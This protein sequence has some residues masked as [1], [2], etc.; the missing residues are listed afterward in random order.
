MSL[1]VPFE[2]KQFLMKYDTYLIIGHKEPDGD[3]VGSQLALQSF[4]HR[5]GKLAYAISA[6]PFTRTEIMPFEHRFHENIP[7]DHNNMAVV[8][9]DCSSISRIGQISDSI[10]LLP[11]AFIDHHAY[12]EC[13][14]DVVF[15]DPAA[16]SVTIMILDIILSM[17]DTPT[18]EEAELMFFG[19]CTDT[20][21][22]RHLSEKRGDVFRAATILADA[23]A[24]PKNVFS[25][26]YGGKSLLTRKLMGELL[27]RTEPYFEGKLLITSMTEEDQR[28]YGI[29][30][31]DS[32]MLYQLLMTVAGVEAVMVIRQETPV[33]CTIGL[34]SRD[35]IDVAR[36]A[37]L[38]GGGGHK[39][40]AGLSMEGTID[41]VRSCLVNA[42]EQI[43]ITEND[44]LP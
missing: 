23:G 5:K 7:Q 19:L 27:F 10:P 15:V 20:G 41:D 40:A 8:I 37:A 14:G 12:G 36:I 16:A 32:D 34:R 42:F 25:L 4:L 28:R 38:F 11:I 22:F 26:I 18:K 3:C 24:S 1:K 9:L 17:N 33:N 13:E 43:F 30:S 44:S 6:G 31:R 35:K 39:Q 21:F 29:A 2:L